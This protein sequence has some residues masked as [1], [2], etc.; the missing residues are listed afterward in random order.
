M[1]AMER[2]FKFTDAKGTTVS[3]F[4]LLI[5]TVKISQHVVIFL[6][7]NTHQLSII[8]LF[9]LNVQRKIGCIYFCYLL[10]KKIQM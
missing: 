8:D 3:T 2:V 6:K 9:R 1:I 5:I 7:L 10:V 4:S